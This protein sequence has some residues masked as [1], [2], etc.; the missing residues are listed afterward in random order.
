MQKRSHGLKEILLELHAS[1]LGLTD[2]KILVL[3]APASP[4][5]CVLMPK[6]AN[7]STGRLYENCQLF[8]GSLNKRLKDG[9]RGKSFGSILVE[10][11]FHLFASSG[12]IT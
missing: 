8:S 4:H 2:L 5:F 1:E 6:S 9:Q 7:T 12:T 11:F 10:L 3:L